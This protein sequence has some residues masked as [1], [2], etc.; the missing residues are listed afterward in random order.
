[1]KAYVDICYCLSLQYASSWIGIQPPFDTLDDWA[2]VTG[3]EDKGGT[4]EMKLSAFASRL[5][6]DKN[7]FTI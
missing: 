3:S 1:M 5:R 2:S 7:E 4:E 6:K